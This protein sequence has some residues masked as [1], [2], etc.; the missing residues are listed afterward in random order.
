MVNKNKR[1]NDRHQE[2]SVEIEKLKEQKRS[3]SSSKN[4]QMFSNKKPSLTLKKN[5]KNEIISKDKN[6]KIK[7]KHSMVLK[8]R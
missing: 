5:I 2:L 8:I 7:S 4:R 3:L 6:S 1:L